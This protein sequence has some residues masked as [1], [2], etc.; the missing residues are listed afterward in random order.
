MVNRFRFVLG[1]PVDAGWNHSGQDTFYVD[2][3][4]EA[5]HYAQWKIH[6]K[7][8]GHGILSSNPTSGGATTVFY[9]SPTASNVST[10]D[11]SY[12]DTYTRGNKIWSELNDGSGSGLDA[13]LLDGV[14]GSSFL[15]SDANDSA[16]GTLTL[17]GEVISSRSVHNYFRIE[18]SNTSEAMIRYNNSTSNLWY[19]GIRASISNGL[20]TSDYHIYSSASGE[21]VLGV[22]AAGTA[23]SKNQGT[24]WGSSNDGSGSGLDA[25]TVD[26]LH[27]TD[28]VETSNGTSTDL[29][30]NISARMFSFGTSTANRPQGYGQGLTIISSGKNHNNINNWA[31]QIAFGTDEN[32]MYFRGKTNAGSWNSWRTAW[33]TGNDGSGSGLDADTVDGIQGSSFLRSNAADTFTGTL[34][35]GLQQALVA[36]NYGRGVFGLYSATRYQHV[37]S[38]GTAYKTS[39]DGTSYGNMYGL[40]FTHTNIGT[41]AN[42]AISGLSHQLQLRMNGTLHAAIGSGIWTSGNITAYSDIAVKTNLEVIPNALDKVCQLNGYT[43]DRTDYEVDPVTGE[44]PETRQAGVVAQEVEKVLPE[45]VSGEDGNKAVAYGN[46]VSILIEAIKELKTEVDDLKTQLAEKE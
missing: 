25:D 35:M 7:T 40:T 3:Y 32:S 26:S 18:S 33:H 45:V 22:T 20:G 12:N 5:A 19:V 4:A 27:G 16:S 37:W 2:L 6:A 21:S 31:T 15:R 43:Y 44:M 9:D 30:N 8:F 29:N 28:I 42:Q 41:G 46:M 14:Q 39:D 23:M 36:N 13:D 38:M 17:N 34:T 10:F 11:V 1:T 24:L